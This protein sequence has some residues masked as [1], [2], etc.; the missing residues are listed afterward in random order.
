M[1]RR[2]DLLE[3]CFPASAPASEEIRR[4]AYANS[5]CLMFLVLAIIGIKTPIFVIASH[6]EVEPAIPVVFE[7][8]PVQE[9]Q[10]VAEPQVDPDLTEPNLDLVQETPRVVPVLA[11]D[12]AQVAFAIP[13]EG[14]VILTPAKFAAPPPGILSPPATV[15]GNPGPSQVQA[16]EF[17]RTTQDGGSY[18]EPAYPRLALQRGM[19][20]RVM[21]YVVVDESGAVRSAEVRD[22]SGW[23]FL[24]KHTLDHVKR[25][26]QFP[27]GTVRHYLLPFRYQRSKN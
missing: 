16:L 23:T 21:L 17:D 27:A 10:P 3:L 22:S 8:P 2:S 1:K 26:Y 12:S 14:P 4:L 13:V 24:D 5:I 7:P 11:V 9:Q 18:P 19:E 15:P 25:S 6:K 20:G